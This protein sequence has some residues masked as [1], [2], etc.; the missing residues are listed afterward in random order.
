MSDAPW[1]SNGPAATG[2]GAP[3]T[4]AGAGALTDVG[5]DLATDGIVLVLDPS[6]CVCGH[7]EDAHEHY[8]PGTDCAL[9]DCPKFRRER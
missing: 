5:A 8:R 4:G 2:D 6:T 7:G 9:C 3:A 1:T